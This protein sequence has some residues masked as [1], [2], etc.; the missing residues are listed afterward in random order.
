MRSEMAPAQMP[1]WLL[2]T[3]DRA[4]NIRRRE[5]YAPRGSRPRFVRENNTARLW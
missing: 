5:F 4:A 2:L 1:A 3:G